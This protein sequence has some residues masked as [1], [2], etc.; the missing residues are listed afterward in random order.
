MSI[1]CL[2]F[3]PTIFGI[4]SLAIYPNA[5]TLLSERALTQSETFAVALWLINTGLITPI[6]GI[7][8]FI[9]LVRLIRSQFEKTKIS[10][11]ELFHISKKFFWSLVF[12]N[13]LLGCVLIV[14]WILTLPGFGLGILGTTVT[15]DALITLGNVLLTIGVV[16]ACILT[17]RWL[18][19]YTYAPFALLFEDHHGRKALRRSRELI[20][21]R[22][23]GI[24][25]RMAVPKIIFLLIV[26]AAEGVLSYAAEF[27]VSN[28][29]GLNQ[30]LAVRLTGIL[31]T[32]IVS[33]G[34]I[35]AN[36]LMLTTDG[37]LY[38][39]LKENRQKKSAEE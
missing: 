32:I 39:S 22:F 28:A 37:L 13:L 33:T 38:Q 24:L 3:I 23:W 16:V 9:G 8:V 10:L 12:I 15:N 19:Y 7:F 11:N 36:P 14:P 5:S 6:V 26:V 29:V 2:L 35:F 25:I 21:G 34:A 20:D 31:A 30:D 1:S 18:I 17:V 4:I 27:L